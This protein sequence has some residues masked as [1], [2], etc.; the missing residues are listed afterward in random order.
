MNVITQKL[1][2]ILH[3]LSFVRKK[4]FI[5]IDVEGH[6]LDVLKGFSLTNW[7][8]KIVLVQDNS[9]FEDRNVKEYMYKNN[10]ICFK[11]TGVNDRYVY[12]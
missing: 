11:K 10:Y 1:D 3:S 6:E 8:P 7:K 12:K 4:V 2:Q 5:S 9:N